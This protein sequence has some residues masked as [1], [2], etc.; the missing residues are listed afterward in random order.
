MILKYGESLALNVTKNKV[1]GLTN[2]GQKKSKII[3]SMLLDI[4]GP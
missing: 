2:Y 1:R 4:S 3:D